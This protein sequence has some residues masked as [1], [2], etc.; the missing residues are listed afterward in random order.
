MDGEFSPDDES[1][2]CHFE[3]D[4]GDMPHIPE[5]E[6][7]VKVVEWE[8]KKIFKKKRRLY[9]LFEICE[10]GSPYFGKRLRAYYGIANFIG[11]P[12]KF[13]NFKVGRKHWFLKQYQQVLGH[14]HVSKF[15]LSMD[16]LAKVQIRVRVEDVTKDSNKGDRSGITVYS[17]VAE[18]LSQA[19][20]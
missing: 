11:K 3:I 8:T 6:Y 4:D 7:I 20:P 2:A 13:G 14:A 10:L 1:G 19:S 9:I 5:G 15:G 16:A 12:R 17:K 18:M